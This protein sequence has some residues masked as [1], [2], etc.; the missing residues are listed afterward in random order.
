MNSPPPSKKEPKSKRSDHEAF[1]K[2]LSLLDPDRDRAGEKYETLRLKL[3]QF[4]RA[5]GCLAREDLTD[6]VFDRLTR[7]LAEGEEIQNVFGYGLGV[8]RLVWLESLKKPEARRDSFD[9]LQVIALTEEN[10]IDKKSRLEC[11]DCC[12]RALPEEDGSLL[13]EYCLSE[14]GSRS[15]TRQQMADRLQIPIGALRIRAHRI[16]AKFSE[17][18]DRCLKDG[19]KKVVIL[20]RF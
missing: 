13:V 9:D 10:E 20:S 1:E 12:L 8:A 11:L 3:A 5:R 17:C 16:K 2:L 15:A 18:F 14:H 19:P 7:K 6:E 4:F